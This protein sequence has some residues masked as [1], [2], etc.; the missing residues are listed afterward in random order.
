MGGMW[1]TILS[2]ALVGTLAALAG[3]AP[4]PPP[5]SAGCGADD[6]GIAA[7]APIAYLPDAELDRELDA[8]RDVGARWLRIDF[9][10]SVIEP[11]RGQQNWAVTD[12]VVDRARARGLDVVGIITYTPPWARAAGS[13][14]SHGRPADPAQFGAFAQQVAQ[15]YASRVTHWEIWNEP[16][17]T[18]FF[19]PLPSVDEY[20][21]LLAA[22][23]PAIKAVQPNARILSGGLAPAVDN[24]S[25]ISPVTYVEQLYARGA[26]QFFDIL[27][28]HPYSYPALPSDIGTQNWNTFYRMRLMRDIM[29]RY[30]DS[31]APIWATEFGAPTGTAPN[32]VSPQ[33]QADILADGIAEARRLGWVE[34][35]FVYS[36]RDRGTDPFD[37]EQ[38]FG[39]LTQNF[40]EKPARAVLLSAATCATAGDLRGTAPPRQDTVG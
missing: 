25:D 34:K 8:V 7:G 20:V 4:P 33:H 17:L 35:V 10:W 14:D 23:A 5:P 31:A 6:I 18:S 16:N 12:R 15:R 36:I 39:L 40:S 19:R 28:V 30:G 26:H 13:A 11:T 3:C 1:R 27:A 38:N 37:V 22:A 21:R 9:D 32:A 2:I 24:G 29:V